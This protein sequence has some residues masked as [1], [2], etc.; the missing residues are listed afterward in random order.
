MLT[1][2]IV[3]NGP[4]SYDVCVIP[5]WDVGSSVVEGFERP[6]VAICRHA[7]LVSHFREDGWMRISEADSDHLYAA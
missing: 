3:V 4:G 1:C 6:S 5:H 2:E 7:D